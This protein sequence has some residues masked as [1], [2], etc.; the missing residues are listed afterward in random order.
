MVGGR[1]TVFLV[2]EL[3]AVNVVPMVRV[4]TTTISFIWL[5]IYIFHSMASH[6]LERN[7]TLSRA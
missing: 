2:V 5:R 3:Q 6:A 4:K 1:V 7:T